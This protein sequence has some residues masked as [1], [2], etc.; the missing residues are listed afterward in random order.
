MQDDKKMIWQP[1]VHVDTSGW[2][3][4][5]KNKYKSCKKVVKGVIE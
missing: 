2:M 4:E 1:M 3:L 5:R